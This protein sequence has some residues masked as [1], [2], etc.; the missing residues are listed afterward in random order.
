MVIFNP[1]IRDGEILNSNT[2]LPTPE[3]VFTLCAGIS[4][5]GGQVEILNKF[6]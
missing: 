4:G 3:R 2:R 5:N 6:E 1:L